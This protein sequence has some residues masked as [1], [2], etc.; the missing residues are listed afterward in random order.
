MKDTHFLYSI[1]TLA[2]GSIIAILVCFATNSL[3]KQTQRV[4][5]SSTET[6]PK[7]KNCKCCVKISLQ[8][9]K[10]LLK[11]NQ[12]LQ[13]QRQ[14]Y[15]IATELIE[16]YGLKEGIHRIKQTYPGVAAQLEFFIKKHTVAT[17]H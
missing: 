17:K 2:L 6:S 4:V 10:A 15:I 5:S 9:L 1:V 12:A 7:T 8:E 3:P 13:K 16:Q 14:T 11:Q